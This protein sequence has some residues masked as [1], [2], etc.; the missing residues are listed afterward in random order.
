MKLIFF[1]III[2][3]FLVIFFGACSITKNLDDNDYILEKNRVSINNKLIQSDSLNRF[4]VQEK[5]NKFFGIPVQS[6]IYQ[7]AKKNSDSIFNDWEQND[8]NRKG[9]KK[10]LS[11]K[12]FLQLKNY[13]RSWNQWKLKNGEPI[14]LI[15]SLKI[16]QSLI[17]FK[18]YFQNI[19]YLENEV[20]F[21]LSK[22]NLK[23]KYASI[24][25]KIETGPQYYIGDVNLLSK[26]K[27]IDSI[28]N[29]YLE[30]SFLKKNEIFKT[31]NFQ[32]ERDRINSLM[33]NNGIYNFQINSVFFDVEIDSTRDVYS[34]PVKIIIE[35]DDYRKHNIKEIK[36]INVKNSEEFSGKSFLTNQIEFGLNESFNDSLRSKTIQNLNNLD[37]FSFPS[38]AY[39]YINES[40]N[41]LSANIFLNPKKKYGLGFGFDIKQSDI[42]DIGVSFENRFKSRNIFK[43]GENLELSAVGSIGKSNDITI[44]QVYFDATLKLP[45]FIFLKNLTKRFGSDSKSF[46]SLGSTNQ[47]NIGLDRTSFRFN[48]DYAWENK[49][50]FFNFSLSDVELINNRNI[51]NYFNIYTNSYNQLNKIAQNNSSNPKYFT[52]GNLSIPSGVN[53]FIKDVI[54][55]S[56]DINEP[57]DI[58]SVQYI[59][60][61]RNRLT[62][63]NLIIGST[64]TVSNNYDN[65]YDKNNFKQWRFKIKTAGN[66]TSLLV[67]KDSD[68]RKRISDLEFSQF[69]KTEFS[70][71][72]HWNISDNS[73][74]AFRY[75]SG[76]AIPFGNSRNIPFSESF[77]G[78]G[79][80]DNRA[81]QVYR[82]G[83]GSSGASNE[84]NEANF[85]LAL[86]FEYRFNILGRFNGA[87]FTDFGNIWNV[88]DDNEDKKRTFES[89][90][91]LNEIAIGSGFGL[92][93]D[94]SLFIFRLDMGLKTYNPSLEKNR[95][96][97]KDFTLKKAVFNIG[98]NYPF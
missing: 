1:K 35:G 86:N 32:R 69:I 14:A 45:K 37:L 93:Y 53:S 56:L 24:N 17:N 85:K 3:F 62:S 84:F 66:L 7:S 41:E 20:E 50:S 94:S 97:L 70:F 58:E 51:D 98:L 95:R 34:L 30:K 36:I 13:Y 10:F 68:G 89:F 42:E 2:I 39:E 43:N 71:I 52:Q 83:P 60:N 78:G 28:Y 61:R 76:I 18:S 75:F 91:D 47:K 27:I 72:K 11:E 12:Q 44:S 92:R 9:L 21:D 15:D 67:K 6:I 25:Y 54:D 46:I 38:I 4:I 88:L 19:G 77:F 82:L 74:F 73:L 96:W 55:G 80:N 79:S 57:N 5:N 48:L 40:D 87:I 63:N 26:S 90:K 64:F 22:D 59:E 65:K 8:K 23:E 16:N 49:N 29:I 33:K 81:W 31:S